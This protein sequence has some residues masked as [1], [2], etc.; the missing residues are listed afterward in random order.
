MKRMH[1]PCPCHIK[2]LNS[3]ITAVII[4]LIIADS[5]LLSLH[6]HHVWMD[7]LRS[8]LPVPDGHEDAAAPPL[9]CPVP[10][11]ASARR[12]P[13]L[14]A[15]LLRGSANSRQNS[16]LPAASI[17]SRLQANLRLHLLLGCLRR[18]TCRVLSE[19][20]C[21][22]QLGTTTSAG[23]QSSIIHLKLKPSQ[24]Q[25]IRQVHKSMQI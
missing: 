6:S 4:F 23:I 5:P 14:F 12:H 1:K 13:E 10:A 18:S 2:Q 8:G 9:G 3:H 11:A 19:S 17:G 16:T 25:L 7:P 15:T 22:K 24:L 20:I 21:R